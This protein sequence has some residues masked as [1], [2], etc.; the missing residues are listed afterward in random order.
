MVYAAESCFMVGGVWATTEYRLLGTGGI[1]SLK[2]VDNYANGIVPGETVHLV[3]SRSGEKR[4]VELKTDKR[5]QF[6]VV[7]PFSP[8][9][10]FL[11]L[12]LWKGVDDGVL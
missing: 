2:L 11:S 12:H 4:V 6:H 7:A 8:Y 3:L 1:W 5:C 10:T 9:R